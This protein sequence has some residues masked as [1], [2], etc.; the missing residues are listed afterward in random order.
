MTTGLI[1]NNSKLL[2]FLDSVN[3]VERVS[4]RLK[5]NRLTKQ[6]QQT[7]SKEFVRVLKITAIK[8]HIGKKEVFTLLYMFD[9]LKIAFLQL[10]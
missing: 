7:F 2:L 3:V 4:N 6:K 1:N 5:E 9:L 8:N 10:I